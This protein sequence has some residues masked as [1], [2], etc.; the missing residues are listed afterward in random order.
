MTAMRKFDWSI[1]LPG[2][3]LPPEEQDQTAFRSRS[4][5]NL[6]PKFTNKALTNPDNEY[7]RTSI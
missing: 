3:I 1:R 6:T 4:T 5:A 2:P 7:G